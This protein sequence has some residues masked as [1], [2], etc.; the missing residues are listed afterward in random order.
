[1]KVKICG[2]TTE[3]EVSFVNSCKPDF[4]GF[5]LC[6]KS[7][8]FVPYERAKR[9]LSLLSPDIR[10]VG[11]FLGNPVEEIKRC[12]AFDVWQLHEYTEEA[13]SLLSEK[14]LIQAFSVRGE[15]DIKRA[16]RSRADFILLDHGKGGTGQSFDWSLPLP[17]R[18]FF[19]AGG[20]DEEKVKMAK[21]LSPY[22]VD[23]SSGV[24]RE[25]K[26]DYEKIRRFI[27]NARRES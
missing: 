9:L 12:T 1:M 25:G 27:E 6:R 4:V 14:L 23:V 3:E 18:P 26:K 15:E 17:S 21:K 20:L 2:I 10:S 7:K 19:L 11:V 22:A 8:R 24:E 5:V 13:L 16:E